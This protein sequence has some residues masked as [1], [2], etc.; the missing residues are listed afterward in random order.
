MTKKCLALK[1]KMAP[2]GYSK[3]EV[4]HRPAS[5]QPPYPYPSSP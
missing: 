1:K 4:K 5:R 3:A 2:T